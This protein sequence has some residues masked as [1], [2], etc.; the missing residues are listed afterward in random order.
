MSYS[1]AVNNK[2][3][4]LEISFTEKPSEA[5]RNTL[6]GFKFRWNPKKSIWYGFADR[7]ELETALNGKKAE[8]KAGAKAKE[9]DFDV[10]VGDLFYSSWGYEQ[11][12]VNF[13]QVVALVGKKSVRIREVHPEVL[14][15]NAV[16]GMAA[17]RKYKIPEEILPAVQSI[18]IEGDEKGDLKRLKSYASDGK[19]DPIFEVGRGGYTCHKYDGGKLYESWYY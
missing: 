5:I 13:F 12:N 8:K 16:C 3:N 9:F 10:K 7:E 4:S 15:E 11:T 1:I 18:F 6:K 14:E 19:S 2:F 17:D